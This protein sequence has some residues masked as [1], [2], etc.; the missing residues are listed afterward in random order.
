VSFTDTVKLA[1]LIVT[2]ECLALGLA[3]MASRA[4]VIEEQQPIRS[5]MYQ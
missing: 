1:V 5:A 2:I 3:Y 4:L